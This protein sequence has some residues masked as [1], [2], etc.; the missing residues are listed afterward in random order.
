MLRITRSKVGLVFH[1]G[2]SSMYDATENVVS[3]IKREWVLKP[4]YEYI[5]NP[6]YG[7]KNIQ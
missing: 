4:S 1:G 7:E 2:Y 6:Q 3:S 5:Q